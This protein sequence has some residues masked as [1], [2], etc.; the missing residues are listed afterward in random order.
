MRRDLSRRERRLLR[1]NES[2]IRGCSLQYSG[3]ADED[4]TDQYRENL[5]Q[6]SEEDYLLSNSIPVPLV[7]LPQILSASTTLFPSSVRYELYKQQQKSVC[8]EALHILRDSIFTHPKYTRYSRRLEIPMPD[9]EHC[10]IDSRTCMLDSDVFLDYL[11]L[12]RCMAEQERIAEFIS[13][14]QDQLSHDIP[15]T[16]R[17]RSTRQSTRRGREH[18]FDQI[19]PSYTWKGSDRTSKDIADQLATMSMLHK[20]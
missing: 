10:L 12:L 11:P 13:K 14:A 5:S 1:W 8:T 9:T 18:Y 16:S 3:I 20:V 2:S 19:V 15:S 4:E 17:R 6:S 7:D